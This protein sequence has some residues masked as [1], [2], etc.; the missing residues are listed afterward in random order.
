MDRIE[1]ESRRDSFL[2]EAQ[3]YALA[4]PG[5][6]DDL[7]QA[8]V[9]AAGLEP[10]SAVLDVGCGTG[11]ATEWFLNAGFA[12][13]GIDRSEQML[14]LARERLG[15]QPGLKLQHLD[16]EAAEDLGSFRGLVLATSYHWLDP[17]SR[18]KRCA[19]HLDPGGALFLLWHTHPAPYT[20]Y[21]AESQGIYERLIPGWQPP[22]T[23]GA[24]EEDLLGIVA[25]LEASG[26]FETIERRTSDWNRIYEAELYL[27]LLRTYSDHRLLEPEARGRLLHELAELINTRYDGLV[28]RPY[29]SELIVA[30]RNRHAL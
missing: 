27:R 30:L 2:R 14:R 11:Q 18:A 28:D 20:G 12:V 17:G 21:F 10:G 26:E 19:G 4:R 6:P 16:F 9:E 8:G 24:K 22:P 5:Y 23:P 7:L 29:R 1:R 15:A 13:H 25:E 3:D